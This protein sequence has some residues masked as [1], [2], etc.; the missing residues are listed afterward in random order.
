MPAPH[1]QVYDETRRLS[2]EERQSVENALAVAA[3]KTGAEFL[4]LVVETVAGRAFRQH[5]VEQR[6]FLSKNAGN[7][8]L[9]VVA[10]GDRHVEI[11]TNPKHNQLLTPALTNRL[12]VRNAVPPL[13]AGRVAEGIVASAN[14]VVDLLTGVTAPAI[15]GGTRK[16]GA[17]TVFAVLAAVVLTIAGILGHHS[18]KN[19]TCRGC[20][21]WGHYET[22]VLRS[23]TSAQDGLE[24]HV[25]NCPRCHTNYTWVT[26]IAYSDSSS[27]SGAD[28]SSGGGGDGGG[29][30][31]F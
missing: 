1:Y 25:F 2:A 17:K 13:R 18:Y 31:D 23:A 4:A 29:G 6:R 30:A 16:S 20:H 27:S 14:A 22:H 9:I 11:A 5:A 28:A 8:I 26:T 19:H 24:E 7:S 3:R 21:A 12:L 15:Y 10:L